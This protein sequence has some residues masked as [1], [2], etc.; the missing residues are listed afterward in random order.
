MAKIKNSKLVCV[1]LS[2]LLISTISVYSV[3]TYESKCRYNALVKEHE[4]LQEHIDKLEKTVDSLNLRLQNKVCNWSPLINAMIEVESEGNKM[5]IGT[6]GDYGVLQIREILVSECNNILKSK[7]IDK[8]YVHTDAFDK[9]KSIEMFHL[10]AEKYVPE[11]DYEKMARIWNGGPT[12]YLKYIKKDNKFVENK[13]YISTT[14]Y[15]IK[16]KNILEKQQN[17]LYFN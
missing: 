5:A 6:S 15:W 17:N 1:L 2:I 16:V 11:I 8:Y 4:V 13:Y 3:R 7:N 9:D 10:I 12:A 14:D